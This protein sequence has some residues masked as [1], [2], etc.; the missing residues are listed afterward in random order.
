MESLEETPL[1]GHKD[2]SGNDLL[3]MLLVCLL[4][5]TRIWVGGYWFGV[6]DHAW[7]VPAIRALASGEFAHDYVFGTPLK[8]SLFLPLMAFLAR[9]LRLEALYFSLYA[10][11]SV[12][13]AVAVYRLSCR[14]LKS[15]AAALL[16]VLL[17]MTQKSV[18]AGAHTWDPLLLPRVVAMPFLLLS[19]LLLTERNFIKAGVLL[20]IAFAIHPLTGVYGG[21]IAAIAVLVGEPKWWKPIALFLCGLAP[22]VAV[23]ALYVGGSRLPWWSTQDQWY[24]AMLIRNLHHLGAGFPL[25]A[26]LLGYG[27]WAGFRLAKKDGRA[28]LLLAAVAIAAIVFTYF[29]AAQAIARIM[30]LQQP[31]LALLNPPIMAVFQPLRISGPLGILILLATAGILNDAL[32]EGRLGRLS[33]AG[34]LVALF[35]AHWLAGAILLVAALITRK[36]DPRRSAAAIA[37]AAS[38]LIVTITSH[39]TLF[40]LLVVVSLAVIIS[41]K[42]LSRVLI[43]PS[44]AAIAALVLILGVLPSKWAPPIAQ[45]IFGADTDVQAPRYVRSVVVAQQASPAFLE[46]ATWA[47]FATRTDQVIII[48]PWW[49]GFRIAAGRPVFGTYKDG[50]LVFFR[51]QLAEEWLARM[52]ALDLRLYTGAGSSLPEG[53]K[54]NYMALDEENILKAA[55]HFEAAYVVRFEPDL[56]AFRQVYSGFDVHVY[57]VPGSEAVW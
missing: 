13:T 53:Q 12:A 24:Q 41:V 35:F 56:P 55:E 36:N 19:W 42:A 3:I 49:E 38:G 23:T 21:A 20:G 50:T 10:A 46:A 31:G 9:H 6:A 22:L 34:A 5:V 52:A 27:L 43:K 1:Q 47:A 15:Q 29:A 44:T 37:L 7:Q 40:V 57:E 4:G 17:L 51:A 32:Q 54:R 25:M 16:A 2:H 30:R 28:E 45:K 11:A 48:P 14:I 8:I 39:K 33:A 18:V 26:A